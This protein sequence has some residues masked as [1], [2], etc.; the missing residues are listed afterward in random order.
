MIHSSRGRGWC[1]RGQETGPGSHRITRKGLWGC[2]LSHLPMSHHFLH[3][4]CLHFCREAPVHTKVQDLRPP[5]CMKSPSVFPFPDG[6]AG[7]QALPGQG[8]LLPDCKSS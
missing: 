1:Q 6:Q 5:L 2:V 4:Q 7:G 3:H 8:H